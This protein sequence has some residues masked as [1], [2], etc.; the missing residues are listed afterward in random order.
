MNA[1]ELAALTADVPDA[2]MRD[3]LVP[4]LASRTSLSSAGFPY[5]S[6]EAWWKL[7]DRVPLVLGMG[8]RA[9]ACL[10]HIE[11]VVGGAEDLGDFPQAARVV[12]QVLRTASITAPPDLWLLR[13]VMG[14]LAALGLIDRLLASETLDPYALE[15]LDGSELDMDLCLLSVRGLL[16][17]ESGPRFRLAPGAA[18]TLSAATPVDPAIPAGVAEDWAAALSGA[19]SVEGLEAIARLGRD[20]PRRIHVEQDG[21]TPTWA[22]IEL[23]YRLV[24]L[25]LGLTSAGML[26][27]LLAA[28][29]VDEGTLSSAPSEVAR[30]ALAILDAAGIR[31]VDGRL[32]AI[33]RRVLERG[34]GPFGIIGA[35]HPYMT[36]LAQISRH[37][38]GSVHVTR[39]ANIAASQ[40]ANKA[41]FQRANDALD[42]F[43]EATGWTYEVF[44]EH[45]LG[46]GE[47]T[48]QRH[49]RSGDA[50]QYVGADL[51]D[52]AIDAS[53]QLQAEGRLPANMRFIRADIGRPG[54]LLDSLSELGIESNGAVML[55]GNGFHEVRGQT[56]RGMV[57]VLRGYCDGGLVLLFTEETALSIE[58]QRATAWNTYHA[59]FRYVHEKSGQGLRPADPGSDGE[60]PASWKE[61]AET[62][63]YRLIE[64]FGR[65]G[66]SIFPF[67]QDGARNPSTSVNFFAVPGPLAD[68]L[69]L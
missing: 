43:S 51:E 27:A 14:N 46:R 4:I 64:R 65:R 35:Y 15:G 16:D 52:Q 60:L 18:F 33:G 32:S 21:W 36:Q 6:R 3:L 20:V 37:G 10:Q 63:G 53:V 25:V 31:A 22:E 23:G 38:K 67:P 1:S 12:W 40:R 30:S 11:A 61:C 55:V 49:L 68:R 26:G 29:V 56:D 41:S 44:I 8:A 69:G 59:G 28:D 5:L 48:R 54:D 62:A 17:R 24:P 2:A 45:A 47:A 58:D 19:G 9:G 57:D 13:A 42:T 7:R 34:P 50:I 66:R 39:G